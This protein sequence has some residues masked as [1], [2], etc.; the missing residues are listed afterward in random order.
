[1]SARALAFV[2]VSLPAVAHADLVDV[3]LRTGY[4]RPV[5]AFDL[6]TH[7]SDGS[8]G[9]IP[10]ALDATFGLQPIERARVDTSW[11]AA[12]GVFVA[13]APTIPTLCTSAPEC[14]S[15]IGSDVELGMLARVHAPRMAFV[16][17]E[18]EI[19]AGWSWS[20]RSLVD[21]DAVST[22]SWN[23]P[24]LLRGAL[25]PSIRLGVHTRFGLVVGGSI[26][27]STSFSLEAPGVTRHG[28]DGA[29][30]H[31]TLD[32]GLRFAVDLDW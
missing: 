10:F 9:A 8:F 14:I 27:R 7:A 17:P 4:A 30:V 24:V 20:S 22:R 28:I 2:L 19:G 29:R 1:M 21:R 25:V 13:Y 6:G 32:F 23:G 26:A 15:S 12:A 5:G 16:L 11:R 3:G 31:G 18:A